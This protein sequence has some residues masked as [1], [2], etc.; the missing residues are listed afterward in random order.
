ML[1]RQAAIFLMLA[2]PARAFELGLPI[3]CTLGS[4]CFVQQYVDRDPGPGI[5]DY[6]CGAAT[7]DG[8]DGTDI[9]VKTLADVDRGVAVLAAAPGVIKGLRDGMPDRVVANDAGRAAVKDRECGNGVVID[10]GEGWET[11]YC[12]MRRGSVAV[13]KGAKVAAGET[14]GDVGYSG[15]A[16]FP[17]VHLTV[18]HNGKAV[19]PFAPGEANSNCGIAADTLWSGAVRD[20]LAYSGGDL[21]ALGFAPA[22]LDFDR[23]LSAPISAPDD[24][25]PALVAYAWAINLRGGDRIDV[26]LAGPDGRL[27]TNSAT[28]DRDKAQYMLFAGKKLTLATWPPGRYTAHVVITRNGASFIDREEVLNLP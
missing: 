5:R 4:D 1:T 19:D 15:L 8:H 20:R 3:A 18:R 25:S 14:L 26:M 24:K 2:T 28:L 23:L 7:N 12:H 17:H 13:A 10:H 11:Q 9:R 21:L 27:A 16:Q 22:A 6:A